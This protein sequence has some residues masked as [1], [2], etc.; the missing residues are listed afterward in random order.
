MS[1][2]TRTGKGSQ[3]TQAEMDANLKEIGVIGAN[4]ASAATVDLNNATGNRIDIT[5]TTTITSFGTA[6][7]PGTTRIVRFQGALT[8]THNATNLILP[9]GA[10][11][12][13]RAGD[14][15]KVMKEGAVASDGWRV[16]DLWRNGDGSD[17]LSFVQFGTPFANGNLG[18]TPTIDPTKGSRQTGTVSASITTFTI[19][20]PPNNLPMTIHIDLVQSTG[21]MTWPGVSGGKKPTGMD[22]ALSTAA[23]ATDRVIA[24]YN[25]S[26]WFYQLVKG[27]A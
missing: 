26:L 15:I 9:V 16:L 13:T 27:W 6:A 1:L 8:L 2:T 4:I 23:G 10:N 3:L 19:T 11:L 12:I 18:A 5:G 24:D 7:P 20:A 22:N 17:L 14:I 21:S 25:G